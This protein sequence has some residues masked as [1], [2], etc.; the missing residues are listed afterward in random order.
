MLEEFEHV[1]EIQMNAKMKILFFV[2]KEAKLTATS[3][4]LGRSIFFT[5]CASAIPRLY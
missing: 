4:V 2:L 5:R 3:L 1:Y